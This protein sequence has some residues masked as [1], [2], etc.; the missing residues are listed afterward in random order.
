MFHTLALL[1]S[2][3]SVISSCQQVRQ[4]CNETLC[5]LHAKALNTCYAH[6]PV[7]FSFYR[8]FPPLIIDIRLK[9]ARK[10][11]RARFAT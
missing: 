2:I 9:N 1:G 3:M 11:A 4:D 5:N 7:P 6:L 10:P 8:A